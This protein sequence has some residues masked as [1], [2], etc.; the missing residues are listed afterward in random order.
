VL[1]FNAAGPEGLIDDKAPGKV[2]LLNAAQRAALQRIKDPHR[3]RDQERWALTGIFPRQCAAD[4]GNDACTMQTQCLIRGNAPVID[5]K[6][7]FL[8]AIDRK[9]GLLREAI[10]ELPSGGEPAMGFVQSLDIK[11]RHFVTGRE[12]VERDIHLPGFAADEWLNGTARIPFAFPGMRQFEPIRRTDGLIT[13]LFLRRAADL[14]GEVTLAAEPVGSEAFRLTARI[15]NTSPCEPGEAA[16][17]G[18]A[19]DRAFLAAHTVFAARNGAF[20]SLRHAPQALQ[21]AA[22]ACD[23]KGTWPVLVGQNGETD[24]LLSSPFILCD[25]PQVMLGRP[26]GFCDGTDN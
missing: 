25:Y 16:D 13:A 20:V 12:A 23:N 10:E 1:A 19:Q 14:A 5:I 9:L 17:C 2:P 22:L 7:R 11:G 8:H 24:L 3:C 18:C 26:R 6:V 4:A 21:T 15:E